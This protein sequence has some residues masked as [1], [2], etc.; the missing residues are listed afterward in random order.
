MEIFDKNDSHEKNLSMEHEVSNCRDFSLHI[1]SSVSSADFTMEITDEIDVSHQ[2]NSSAFSK[3]EDICDAKPS[4][5]SLENT[6][7]VRVSE[8]KERNTL[9][10]KLAECANSPVLEKRPALSAIKINR[11]LKKKM[12][13][14]LKDYYDKFKIYCRRKH[15]AE[16]ALIPQLDINF[17][18]V[19]LN[20]FYYEFKDH[21]SRQQTWGFLLTEFHVDDTESVG[22]SILEREMRKKNAK[23]ELSEDDTLNQ[24]I[25]KIA[26]YIDEFL[27]D[28][29]MKKFE[30]D[31]KNILAC[32]LHLDGGNDTIVFDGDD[33]AC[34]CG[35]DKAQ[36][37]KIMCSKCKKLQHLLCVGLD[38]TFEDFDNYI[39][40]YCWTKNELIE[41]SATL[42]VIPSTLSLQ[43]KQEVRLVYLFCTEVKNLF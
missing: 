24:D 43:W 22:Y 26:T 7:P 30:K 32:S 17:K 1:N 16:D 42:I 18:V 4:D 37:K 20:R 28:K 36:G 13:E 9:K 29:V 11:T 10:R 41:S 23:T 8:S 35:S 38:H 15:S 40:P 31:F 14:L 5:I 2:T 34:K 25:I 3:Q 33:V 21:Y 19:M 39:C 12:K 27:T 6:P